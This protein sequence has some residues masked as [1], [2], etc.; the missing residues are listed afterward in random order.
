[1]HIETEGIVCGVRGHGEHGTVLRVLTPGHGLIAAYVRGGRGRRMRPVLIPGNVV[2]LQL[3]SRTEGQLPQ[4]TVEL[5]HSRAPILSE[6][7]PAS[8]IEWSTAVVT[9]ALPERQPYPRVYEGMTGLLD[10]IEAAP[11]ASRWGVALVRFEML[12]LAE[13]GYGRETSQ[14]PEKL[15]NSKAI[16]WADVLA[17]LEISGEHLFRETISDRSNALHDSRSRLL[18]RL[19]RAAA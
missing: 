6:P 2:S 14:F 8:A 4:A 9:T 10:A 17:A 3:R 11:S 18:D 16:D 1:M 19:R 7:L 5:I 15:G 13:I 12:L